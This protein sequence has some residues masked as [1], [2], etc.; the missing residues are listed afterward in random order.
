MRFRTSPTS[1]QA[2]VSEWVGGSGWSF[3]LD[4]G[5]VVDAFAEALKVG[6]RD[7]EVDLAA[8]RN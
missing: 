5:E 7:V 1:S 3:A 2:R 8:H 6:S 4:E